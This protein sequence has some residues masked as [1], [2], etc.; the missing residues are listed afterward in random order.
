MLITLRGERLLPLIY[1]VFHSLYP[2]V[3]SLA[4]ISRLLCLPS[5][6]LQAE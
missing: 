1:I 6:L 4:I 2:F 3:A 5:M